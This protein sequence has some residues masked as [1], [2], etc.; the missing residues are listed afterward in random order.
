MGVFRRPAPTGLR[1]SPTRGG[2]PRGEDE[3][4]SSIFSGVPGDREVRS[5]R[6]ATPQV[7][8]VP[9]RSL[10]I[11][12]LQAWLSAAPASRFGLLPKRPATGFF[13]WHRRPSTR[14]TSETSLR[15]IQDAVVPSGIK[16]N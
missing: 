6:P 12:G 4:R 5:N 9:A 8:R 16:P 1:P 13:G 10:V 15:P 7:G 3:S 14:P 2:G 11:L